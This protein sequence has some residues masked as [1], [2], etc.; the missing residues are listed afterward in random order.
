VFGISP[1]T[2]GRVL[3]ASP[4]H[5]NVIGDFH[6]LSTRARG[7]VPRGTGLRAIVRG[8]SRSAVVG[9]PPSVM[10]PPSW[11]GRSSSSRWATSYRSRLAAARTAGRLPAAVGST[12]RGPGSNNRVPLAAFK[13]AICLGSADCVNARR[14]EAALERGDRVVERFYQERLRTWRDWQPVSLEASGTPGD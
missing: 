1:A 5:Q 11:A 8:T 2:S 4:A 6:R 12:P 9:T 3:S 14:S 10:R 7:G 13:A